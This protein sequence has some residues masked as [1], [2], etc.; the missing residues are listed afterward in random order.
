MPN[1]GEDILAPSKI[2]APPSAPPAASSAEIEEL[3]QRYDALE[4]VTK[5][6]VQRADNAEAYVSQ[7]TASLQ[8]A[9]ARATM[10]GGGTPP[11]QEDIRERFAN[12]PVSVLDEHYRARTAPIVGAVT[13]NLAKQNRDMAFMKFQQEKIPGTDKS[14]VEVYGKEVDEFMR[15]MPPDT[16]ANPGTYDAAMKWV[17]SQHVDEEVEMRHQARVEAEKR[18]FV[19]GP[20]SGSPGK[21]G[22][23][24]LTEIEREVAKGLG[25]TEEDYLQYRE[26]GQ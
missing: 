8:D 6:A 4:K 9:A 23:P 5:G 15:N 25:L 24:S 2:E 12:D 1:D 18:A 3:K 20:A 21:P 14:L 13:E 7:L 19:E 16:R 17:R 10:G 22:K 11:T 26:G